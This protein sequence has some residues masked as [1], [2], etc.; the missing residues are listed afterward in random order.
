MTT[1]LERNIE[2][3][4]SLLNV[5]CEVISE[6]HTGGWWNVNDDSVNTGIY[7]FP[8]DRSNLARD[9]KKLGCKNK[10][11]YYHLPDDHVVIFG[12]SYGGYKGRYARQL[13]YAIVKVVKK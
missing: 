5:D 7:C 9:I 3:F 2:R 8:S 1:R 11:G 12:A 10:Q 4:A 13:Q 6:G